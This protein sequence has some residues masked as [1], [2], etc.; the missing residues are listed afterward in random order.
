MI[1]SVINVLEAPQTKG[2][3]S[4]DKDHIAGHLKCCVEDIQLRSVN[5]LPLNW[6]FNKGYSLSTAK[7]KNFNI[8]SPTL[9]ML[10]GENNLSCFTS[11]HFK[12]ALSIFDFIVQNKL[13]KC[14]HA[15]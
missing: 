10:I 8:K 6:N 2:I 15:P 3:K 12:T 1:D 11:K 13:Y 7:K 5:F 4:F 9:K 14:V